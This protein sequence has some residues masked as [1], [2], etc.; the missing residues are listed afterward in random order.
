M[1]PL[2]TLRTGVDTVVVGPENP[3]DGTED[4]GGTVVLEDG[5]VVLEDGTFV[6][7]LEEE[8]PTDQTADAAAKDDIALFDEVGTRTAKQLAIRSFGA[9][10][11]EGWAFFAPSVTH[12]FYG[13]MKYKGGANF[14][15]ARSLRQ[16][17][18]FAVAQSAGQTS[19]GNY[20][21]FRVLSEDQTNTFFYNIDDGIEKFIS[22]LE[23]K[24]KK[25][26]NADARRQIGVRHALSDDTSESSVEA[27]MTL[28]SAC[29]GLAPAV[30][31]AGV[32]D[33]RS[34][35]VMDAYRSLSDL[36]RPHSI[37]GVRMPPR[38]A[39]RGLDDAIGLL[40]ANVAKNGLLMLD[41]KPSNI[42]V[43]LSGAMATA[44]AI[45]YD[46]QFCSYQPNA[47]TTCVFV[48]NAVMF[49]L[50]MPQRCFKEGG[51]NVNSK[52]YT[53]RPVVNL[54]ERLRY[55]LKQLRDEDLCVALKEQIFHD[56][57]Q[58]L[59]VPLQLLDTDR[60]SRSIVF[61]ANHYANFDGGSQTYV[62]CP[63]DGLEFD[64]PIWPQLVK[65][66]LERR[67]TE[68]GDEDRA[69][70]LRRAS[71]AP[72]KSANEELSK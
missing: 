70:Q 14:N 10:W 5:T 2:L 28:A 71:L 43:D 32:V 54:K 66:V 44:F 22:G 60:M 56:R 12:T 6:V 1:L 20:N 36:M 34:V 42:V 53:Y 63:I 52:L 7:D 24:P 68:I 57:L 37:K 72:A 65:H 61:L 51:E 50:S 59:P 25:K 58:P 3:E 45:D 31:V 69:D 55:A 33:R 11:S 18:E 29:A 30:H 15:L 27:Y 16:S 38:P 17:L 9:L 13:T 47:D 8:E 67:Q 35:F 39:V 19:G 48:V 40:F 64:A 62:K 46:A 49:L 4:D 26:K 23:K 21:I 41:S